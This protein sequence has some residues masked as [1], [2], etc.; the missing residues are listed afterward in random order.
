MFKYYQS[1][2]GKHH[3]QIVTKIVSK[4]TLSFAHRAVFV[5][6]TET[7]CMGYLDGREKAGCRQ[8]IAR[9]VCLTIAQWSGMIWRCEAWLKYTYSH[10]IFSLKYT[11]EVQF[12]IFKFSLL[13]SYNCL[14][15][16]LVGRRET[17][18]IAY[19][20][21]ALSVC[22]SVWQVRNADWTG[23]DLKIIDV[24]WHDMAD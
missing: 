14:S 21:Q 20:L 7:A 23:S 12:T 15:D 11:P 3:Y 5:I 1:C 8:E 17:R 18:A 10:H 6:F 9:I 22:L 16:I 4:C 19:T 2:C 13:S 24:Y